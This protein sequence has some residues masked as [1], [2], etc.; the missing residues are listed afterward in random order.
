MKQTGVGP[1]Q[2]HRGW[3]VVGGPSGFRPSLGKGDELGGGVVTL[4][5]EVRDGGPHGGPHDVRDGRDAD[6]A[7]HPQGVDV[8][9]ARRGRRQAAGWSGWYGGRSRDG[10]CP[11]PLSFSTNPFG[12]TPSDPLGGTPVEQMGGRKC[13]EVLINWGGQMLRCGFESLASLECCLLLWE[14]QQNI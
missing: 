10:E 7:P 14:I 8:P 9:E 2:N 6:Q 4:V 3:L 1:C 12:R 13:A 5:A 11:P